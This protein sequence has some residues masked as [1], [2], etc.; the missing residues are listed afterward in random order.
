MRFPMLHRLIHV[1]LFS[2]AACISAQEIVAPTPEQAGPAKGRMWDDYNIV[3]SFETGYRFAT[4]SG[5][6]ETYRSN[7]NFG[8]GIRLMSGFFSVNSKDGQGRFFDTI[9]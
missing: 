1:C 7:V 3:D 5:N 8:N 2:L 6:Q 9:V 4:V